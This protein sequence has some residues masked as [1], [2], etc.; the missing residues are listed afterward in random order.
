MSG[1]QTF[2]LSALAVIGV[3]FRHMGDPGLSPTFGG[4]P[5][6]ELT[7]EDV[8]AAMDRIFGRAGV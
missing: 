3:R 6:E 4:D 7:P 8:I 1:F 2:G 5:P